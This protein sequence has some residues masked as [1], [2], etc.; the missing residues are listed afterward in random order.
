MPTNYKNGKIYQIVSDQTD[1]VYI[2]STTQKLCQRM[3]HHRSEFFLNKSST[4]SKELMQYSDA[5]ILLIEEY[6]CENKEQ[7]LKREGEIMRT[8]ENRV[9]KQIAGNYISMTQKEYGKQIRMKN[10]ERIQESGKKYYKNNKEIISVKDKDRYTK[11]KEIIRDRQKDYYENNKEAICD[12]S[13]NHYKNNKEAIINKGKVQVK[14]EIC[15]QT[16][17]HSSLTKH[18]QSKKHLANLANSVALVSTSIAD[19][20]LLESQ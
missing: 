5:K 1:K 3:T 20:G 11:N 10:R 19:S 13:K 4:F 2:G 6:P 9:N 7:L 14:C 8:F 18:K 15:S 12:H 17:N 16:M